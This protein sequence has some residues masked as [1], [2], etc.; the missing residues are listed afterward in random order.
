[1]KYKETTFDDIVIED[2]GTWSQICN[3]C[4]EKHFK[5]EVINEVPIEGLVCGVENCNNEASFYIDFNLSS[6]E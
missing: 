2:E 5:G 4:A 3:S 1:M 6:E